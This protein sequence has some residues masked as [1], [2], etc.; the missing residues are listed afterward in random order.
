MISLVVHF[1]DV[2]FELI[3]SILSIELETVP[4]FCSSK[5]GRECENRDLSCGRECD[6][7]ARVDP[8]RCWDTSRE[9]WR[10]WVG[11]AKKEK[12]GFQSYTHTGTRENCQDE[13]SSSFIR[14]CA[15]SALLRYSM[16]ARARARFIFT[17]KK[18]QL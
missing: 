15:A 17:R 18:E 6:K 7:P 4:R 16:Q 8:K 3:C 12:I 2:V 10:A 11:Y 5:L 14:V 9:Y 1:S 13:R